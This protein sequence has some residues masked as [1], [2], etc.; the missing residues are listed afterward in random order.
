MAHETKIPYTHEREYCHAKSENDDVCALY[1]N[2]ESELHV[3]DHG[4]AR[5]PVEH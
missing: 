3:S 2:H 1:K 5:W 4:K